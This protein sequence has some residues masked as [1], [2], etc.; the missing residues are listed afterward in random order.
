MITESLFKQVTDKEKCEDKTQNSNE[1]QNL[2]NG[3]PND[4]EKMQS[5]KCKR[6]MAQKLGKGWFYLAFLNECS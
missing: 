1:Y 5:E 3:K 4:A 6:G 2:R